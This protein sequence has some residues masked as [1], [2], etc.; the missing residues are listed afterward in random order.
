[1]FKL[2]NPLNFR[3]KQYYTFFLLLSLLGLKAQTKN[4]S[5]R[6]FEE[7]KNEAALKLTIAYIED[8]R[9]EEWNS[10]KIVSIKEKTTY[11]Y[12]VKLQQRGDLLENA[13]IKQIL[14]NGDWGGTRKKVYDKYLES[15]ENKNN[16]NFEN[17]DF[18][19]TSVDNTKRNEVIIVLNEDYNKRI[20]E[21]APDITTPEVHSDSRT[22]TEYN[23]S[24][25]SEINYT[26]LLIISAL[27]NFVLILFIALRKRKKPTKKKRTTQNNNP[28]VPTNEIV[29]RSTRK[30]VEFLEAENS[31]LLRRNKELTAEIE[32]Y[33]GL[34]Q[35]NSNQNETPLEEEKAQEIELVLKTKEPTQLEVGYFSSPFEKNKFSQEDFKSEEDGKSLYK[36]ESLGIEEWT[37]TLNDKANYKRALRSPNVFLDPVCDSSNLFSPEASSIIVEETG[38]IKRSGNDWNVIRRPKIKFT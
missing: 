10:D 16:P 7:M 2:F 36:V 35:K 27:L 6:L 30:S 23:P 13:E 5:L 11:D 21:F 32:R 33:R 22:I 3:L 18:E 26:L 12:L 24:S 34:L 8:L 9:L 37:L 38:L 19:P 29:A 1:M 20:K 28:Y 31:K 4:D 25:K 17:I 15:F 14:D